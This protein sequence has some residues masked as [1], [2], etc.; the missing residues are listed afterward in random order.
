MLPKS[1]YAFPAK[2]SSMSF[3]NFYVTGISVEAVLSTK[4]IYNIKLNLFLENRNLS[5]F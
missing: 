2:Y 4:S 1:F 5:N 3:I